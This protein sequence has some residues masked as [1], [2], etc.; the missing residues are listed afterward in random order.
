MTVPVQ[1]NAFTIGEVSPSLFGRF[2]L[3]RN[4]LGAST[5]RNGF[6]SYRGGYYSRAGTAFVGFSKQTGRAYPPRLITFQFNINQ[7]LALEFG[8]F[9][10]R[11][12]LDG[13]FVTNPPSVITGITQ[14]NPCVVTAVATSSGLSAASVDSGVT[15]SY[16]PGDL[17]NLAGGVFTARAQLNVKN[18][19]LVSL[20]INAAGTGIYAPGDTI[21][22]LGGTRT[23]IPYLTVLTTKVIS[24]A[25]VNA[26]GVGTN[27]AQ[28]LTGT[29]GNGTKVQIGVTVAGGIV[30]AITGISVAGDYTTNPTN[31][32]AEPM[33]GAGFSI[34]VSNH[35]PVL[36]LQLG[37][38]AFSI[39]NGGSF[40]TNAPGATFT[41]LSTSGLGVGATFQTAVFGPNQATFSIA[42]SYSVLPANPV[43]QSSTTG[44]GAGATFNVTWSAPLSPVNGDWIAI[45]GIV[46]MT[47]LNGQTF[48]AAGVAGNTFQLHDVYG[49][50][51]DSSAFPAW[52]SS[53]SAAVI[54]TQQTP[55]GEADLPYL[56]FTESADD[57]SICCVNQQTGTE[58]QAQDLKRLAD[59]NWTFSSVIATTSATPPSAA[60]A[61]ASAA[62]LVDYAYVVTSVDPDDGTE[63]VASPIAAVGTAVNIAA[64]AGTITVTWNPVPR[65]SEFNVYKATPGVSAPPPAGALFGFAAKAYG[66]QMLDSN[67]VADFSQVPPTHNDPFAQEP[68]I[69]VSPVSGGGGY[70]TA[71]VVFNSLTGSG[72]VAIPIIVGGAVVDYLISAG[73]SNYQPTDTVT[74]TGDGAAA[75]ASLAVGPASGTYPGAVAY[76]Q[77]R[78]GYAN[79]LNQPDTY[80]FS[81]PGAF[82]NF[83]SRIPTIGSDAIIG[84]PWSVQVNG[85]QF[86]VPMPGGLVVLTGLSAWQL[87]GTGGSSLNPQPLEPA[88]QQAQPQ[89]YNG[90]S[91]TVPPIKIDYDI[92]YVQAKG[93]IVRDLSYQFYTNIY[94]GTDIT[95][96]SSHLFIGFT[97]KE[98]AWCEEPYKVLWAVRNDGTMLA[99]TYL[100]PQEVA[101]WGRSDT[102]GFFESVCSVTEPPVDALYVATQRFPGTNTAYMV[103]LL[104]L[105][106]LIL[107]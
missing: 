81:Q 104:D 97:L 93:S 34:G 45:A 38:L 88:T 54:Y 19:A 2:D 52:I 8:N 99:L 47:N 90:C 3:A 6:V 56:K 43:A 14:A 12:I 42:G 51:I 84:A 16:V 7:G 4:H 96:N 85:I 65:I 86:M 105:L 33:S 89:A 22:L 20:A 80:F 79:T 10:M 44:A 37:V 57:M 74:I 75:T 58:Y 107:L 40:T 27:G 68:I 92:L 31:P 35:L 55:Y 15:V 61:S 46:G 60:T 29:T 36:S 76:Y 32:N 101:G 30:T 17:V 87:T 13:A 59:D 11:V 95:L 25:I 71:A 91:A 26:G 1:Q 102:N 103:L 21:S 53:G 48:V 69:N 82:T 39:S 9:Y 72:A 94:T 73:G 77:E 67:I 106:L 98:W 70:T 41:Q 100:K 28:T 5:F 18:T 63:S 50:A 66:T 62:G 23:I 78:R 83:D 49:N 64:T 24:A